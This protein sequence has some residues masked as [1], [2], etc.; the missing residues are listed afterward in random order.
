MTLLDVWQL[1]EKHLLRVAILG[2]MCTYH[3]RLTHML[4]RL[5]CLFQIILIALEVFLRDLSLTEK[6]IIVKGKTRFQC[7][8]HKNSLQ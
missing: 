5:M 1:A 4:H 3:A 2:E 8:A 6:I 7:K